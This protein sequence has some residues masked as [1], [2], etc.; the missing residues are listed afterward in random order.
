MT[1]AS[2]CVAL[3]HKPPAFANAAGAFNCYEYTKTIANTTTVYSLP[4]L[5]VVYV[6][7]QTAANSSNANTYCQNFDPHANVVW[8]GYTVSYN[9]CAAGLPLLGQW[10]MMAPIRRTS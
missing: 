5:D 7:Y 10:C 6:L 9:T 3:P 1:P 4:A 8:T 2:S